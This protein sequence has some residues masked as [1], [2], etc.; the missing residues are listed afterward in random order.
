[1]DERERIEEIARANAAVAAAQDRSYWLD[2]WHVDL[3]ALMRRRGAS[4]LRATVRALRAVYR[5]LVD[6]RKELRKAVGQAPGK[7]ASTK[8]LVASERE[9]AK[10]MDAGGEQ[11]IRRALAE[12][13]LEPRPEDPWLRPD[14]GPPLEQLARVRAALPSGAR[15][16]L[17]ADGLTPAALLARS[18]PDWRIALY[19]P[20]DPDVY[21]L[22][23]R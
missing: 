11:A 6:A 13:G 18:T 23:P 10:T 20:G 8:Q 21:V 9:R 16:V 3:N 7:L 14:A 1:M 22:E 5:L 17:E 2:R 19:V 4:E 15:V 12:A